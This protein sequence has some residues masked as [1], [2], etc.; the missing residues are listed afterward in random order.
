[1]SNDSVGG[2]P[3]LLLT[4]SDTL[5]LNDND[6]SKSLGMDGPRGW[7]FY[8][9]K[10]NEKAHVHLFGP[11]GSVS[12]VRALR[13]FIRRPKLKLKV[14]EGRIE[15]EP[16]VP[17]DTRPKKGDQLDPVAFSVTSIPFEEPTDVQAGQKR[18]RSNS[19][20]SMLSFLFTTASIVGKFLPTKAQELG[21]P[22]GPLYG[23]LKAGKSVTFLDATNGVETT[24]HSHQVVTPSTPGVAVLVLRYPQ[25]TDNLDK[26]FANINISERLKKSGAVLDVVVHLA[27][28]SRFHHDSSRKWKQKFDSVQHLWINL[29]TNGKSPHRSAIS[30]ADLR[31]K[32]CSQIFRCPWQSSENEET[33]THGWEFQLLPR[34]KRGLVTVTETLLNDDDELRRVAEL[35]KSGAQQLANSIIQKH[36]CQVTPSNEHPSQRGQLFFAGTASA[37]P[38]KYRNVTGM[39]LSNGNGKALLLD[40][41]EGTVGQL[42]RMQLSEPDLDGVLSS[43]SVVWISHPHADHHLS[44]LRLLQQRR[45]S[46]PVL[47]VA[48]PPVTRFLQ[49]YATSIDPQI[50][51]TYDVLDCNAFLTRD[52]DAVEKLRAAIGFTNC[53]SVRVDHCPY[54]YAVIFDGTPFGRVVYS[55]DCRPCPRLVEAAKPVDLLI[56]EATFED[57]M[58]S[59]A[60][61]KK[62]CTIGEALGVAKAMEAKFTVL[63]HF[64]QRYPGIPPPTKAVETAGMHIIFAFDY[65]ILTPTTLRL[66]AELTPALRKLYPEEKNEIKVE[67]KVE[68][69]ALEVL[70]TPGLFANNKLL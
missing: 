6:D 53:Q 17:V 14:F 29:A 46:D 58:K 64:S 30:T 28:P 60:F 15:N 26:F 8:P 54:A 21:V 39:L 9:L 55:G 7:P 36:A 67:N 51:E 20:R 24:V 32:V 31:S 41:G 18:P 52:T 48:P 23:Q 45:A 70:A 68:S 37:I 35:E 34:S 62:H 4:L 27:F 3:G 56:H 33:C 69:K 19:R 16:A 38:C 59:E 5:A 25:F 13:H 50:S 43:I 61:L 44:L 63:T 49:E 12:F 10:Q 40:A 11:T 22:K 1:L 57:D 42:L 2:L 65:Q 47:L 66:A